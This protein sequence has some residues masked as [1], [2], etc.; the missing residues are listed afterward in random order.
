MAAGWQVS[1][2]I[3]H[4]KLKYDLRTRELVDLKVYLAVNVLQSPSSAEGW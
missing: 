2:G 3:S 1:V 4:V